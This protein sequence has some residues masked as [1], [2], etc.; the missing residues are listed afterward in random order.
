M[1]SKE[2]KKLSY[3]EI[4]DVLP[5]ILIYIYVVFIFLLII[6]I[7]VLT[8]VGA[9][10]PHLLEKLNNGLAINSIC[11]ILAISS[12][13]LA[14]NFFNNAKNIRFCF[15]KIVGLI[16]NY[17]PKW[18]SR[19]TFFIMIL[20]VVWESNQIINQL[21]SGYLDKIM[22]NTINRFSNFSGIIVN[23]FVFCVQLFIFS[24]SDLRVSFI[25]KKR[26]IND[27]KLKDISNNS[28]LKVLATNKGRAKGTYRFLGICSEKEKNEI[29]G[30]GISSYL[31][32][33]Q[34]YFSSDY[35]SNSILEKYTA[36][37]DKGDSCVYYLHFNHFPK[38]N[39][40][41]MF[42][43]MPNNLIFIPVYIDRY[44]NKKINCFKKN[45][46]KKWNK[47]SLVVPII[48]LI[49]I[50]ILYLPERSAIKKIYNKDGRTETVKTIYNKKYNVLQNKEYSPRSTYS[51]FNTT[52]TM[53]KYQIVQKVNK[54]DNSKNYQCFIELNT[55]DR[56]NIYFDKC[57]IETKEGRKFNTKIDVFNVKENKNAIVYQIVTK[58]FYL[59]DSKEV[60]DILL[61]GCN[62]STN[63]ND[64]VKLIV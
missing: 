32:Q 8:I 4:I 54:R 35:K 12:I 42:L 21:S 14:K 51:I 55:D 41:I 20:I 48:L 50:G 63:K 46:N 47:T 18:L 11:V 22:T 43:E 25:Y 49:T 5:L 64:T 10:W 16:A 56:V 52:L 7:Y 40:F 24:D 34:I 27:H 57:W 58:E 36:V 28:I 37:L 13:I 38:N 29:Y 31:E 60:K 33:P 30:S 17:S 39:F 23:L 53:K 6:F 26:L 3:S 62:I 45:H 19:L 15:N 9:T 59:K 44:K 61:S 1:K 2:N